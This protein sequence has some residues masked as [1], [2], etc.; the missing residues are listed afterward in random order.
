MIDTEI[1]WLLGLSENPLYIIGAALF[2]TILV[3]VGAMT[4]A[5]RFQNSLI[6]HV[7]FDQVQNLKVPNDTI[8]SLLQ[9]HLVP[10]HVIKDR[11]YSSL[12]SLVNVL[13]G[14]Q[15]TCDMA[16]EIWPPA[17][18]AYNVIVP[19]FLN[20]PELIFGLGAPVE[21]VSIAMYASS[22]ANECAYCTSHCCSFALRRGSDPK[23]FGND[24]KGEDTS[25][26]KTPVQSAATAVA[27][28]LGTVPC[29]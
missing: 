8:F 24:L 2:A 10:M 7:D 12:L 25:V 9:P 19:N 23:L 27:F 20:L 16:L 28:G 5:V 6:K 21:L 22:R 1:D 14:V 18:E 15:L 29:L 13:I 26:K 3:F 11:G 17:F 4:Y